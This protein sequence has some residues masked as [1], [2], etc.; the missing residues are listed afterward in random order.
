MIII[1]SNNL[2]N[3]YLQLKKIYSPQWDKGSDGLLRSTFYS[4]SRSKVAKCGLTISDNDL[5]F[6]CPQK[7]LILAII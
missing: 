6:A 7:N 5:L 3:S 2:E 1:L 4:E